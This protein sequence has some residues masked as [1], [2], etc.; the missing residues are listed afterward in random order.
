DGRPRGWPRGHD[1]LRA[2]R[3][4]G[5]RFGTTGASP[6]PTGHRADASDPGAPG[7]RATA[8]RWRPGVWKARRPKWS[9]TPVP[10]RM[11]SHRPPAAWRRAD[12]HRPARARARRV[13]DRTRDARHGDT[14][15]GGAS[16][17][18]DG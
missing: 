14:A 10:S 7:I 6:R 18:V 9:G 11:A 5:I 15:A 4:V 2:D 1:P 13:P 8:Y 16:L 17:R 12:L 3:G